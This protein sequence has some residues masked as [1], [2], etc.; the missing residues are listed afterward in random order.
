MF[1]LDRRTPPAAATRV[2]TFSSRTRSR[3]HQRWTGISRSPGPYS[4]LTTTRHDS[5]SRGCTWARLAKC[6]VVLPRKCDIVANCLLRCRG[7]QRVLPRRTVVH[8]VHRLY[9]QIH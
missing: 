5:V 4:A 9:V 3:V 8:L 6:C 2:G 7:G 1:L